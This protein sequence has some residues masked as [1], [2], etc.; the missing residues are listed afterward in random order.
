MKMTKKD[1]RLLFNKCMKI[2]KARGCQIDDETGE[3]Y[4]YIVEVYPTM[5]IRDFSIGIFALVINNRCSSSL[6]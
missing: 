2:N 5:T 3:V 1:F 4:P 6:S